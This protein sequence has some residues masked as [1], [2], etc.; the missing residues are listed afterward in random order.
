VERVDAVAGGE[1]LHHL[2]ASAGAGRVAVQRRDVAPLA[3]GDRE[4]PEIV[5]GNVAPGLAGRRP[6]GGPDE[7]GGLRMGAGDEKDETEDGPK[8]SHAKATGRFPCWRW[9]RRRPARPCRTAP[10]GACTSCA[11]RT[12]RS[13]RRSPSRSR[14]SR[15]A[16]NGRATPV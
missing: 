15:D 9:R 12:A 3:E 14:T 4:E 8:A 16:R 13:R 1:R 5:D 10:R 7:V 6:R 2:P 11:C